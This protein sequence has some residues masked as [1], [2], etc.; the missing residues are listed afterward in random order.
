VFPGEEYGAH[1]LYPQAL[2]G[3]VAH[4]TPWVPVMYDG[5]HGRVSAYLRVQVETNGF[6]PTG[7]DG[8]NTHFAPFLWIGW[9]HLLQPEDT[10]V[11][12]EFHAYVRDGVWSPVKQHQFQEDEPTDILVPSHDLHGGVAAAISMMLFETI[13]PFRETAV[14]C[15]SCGRGRL[16]CRRSWYGGS[17]ICTLLA[18]SGFSIMLDNRLGD[19]GWLDMAAGSCQEFS[20]ANMDMVGCPVDSSGKLPRKC[21]QAGMPEADPGTD[22]VETRDMTGAVILVPEVPGLTHRAICSE[23]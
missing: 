6:P 14:G 15:R 23:I 19:K 3:D 5:I 8:C 21:K 17:R 9:L 7:G 18:K 22:S 13:A 2:H 11:V 20:A 16:G 4:P 12:H 1:D 10:P